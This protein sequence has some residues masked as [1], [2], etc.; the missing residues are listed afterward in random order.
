[1]WVLKHCVLQ[2]SY[3]DKSPFILKVAVCNAS[4]FLSRPRRYGKTLLL[5]TFASFGLETSFEASNAYGRLD[6]EVRAGSRYFVLE[7]KFAKKYACED[8]LLEQAVSQIK[9]KQ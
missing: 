8:M 1:M 5:S 3:I 6:L 4:F 9:S 7:F 2:D